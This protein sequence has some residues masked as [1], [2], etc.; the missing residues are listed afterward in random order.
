MSPFTIALSDGHYK[1]LDV[2]DLARYNTVFRTL[3]LFI[4][5]R[6][7]KPA[8]YERLFLECSF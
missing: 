1:P 8:V 4:D 3:Y 5:L 2:V 7:F 6:L